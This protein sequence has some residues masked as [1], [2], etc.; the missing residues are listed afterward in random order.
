[1]HAA[2]LAS[3]FHLHVPFLVHDH[4][5]HPPPPPLFT[6]SLIHNHPLPCPAYHQLISAR[7]LLADQQWHICVCMMPC[8]CVLVLCMR[9]V[10]GKSE[11]YYCIIHFSP[12]LPPSPG[13]I[14]L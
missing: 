12:S 7:H 6:L 13:P 4:L 14:N 10:G 8:V 2:A 11:A 3:V 9:A 5:F 1:M